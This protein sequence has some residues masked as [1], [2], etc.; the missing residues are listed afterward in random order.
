MS[1]LSSTLFFENLNESLNLWIL[2]DFGI[3]IAQTCHLKV[4]LVFLYA[5]GKTI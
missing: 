3:P 2:L 5:I 4:Q 1:F